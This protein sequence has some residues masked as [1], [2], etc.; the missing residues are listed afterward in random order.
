MICLPLS[1]LNS[2]LC[3]VNPDKVAQNIRE[4]VLLFQ[5]ECFDAV[6]DYF[7]MESIPVAKAEAAQQVYP[8]EMV[9][10]HNQKLLG[11]RID[12]TC[13]VAM[14]PIVEGMGLYWTTQHRK[15][16]ASNR[17]TH[18]AIPVQTSSNV[19]EMICIP[20]TKL[21]GWMCSVN[22]ERVRA[23]LREKVIMYQEECFIVLYNYF[24]KG[25][26]I[27]SRI[28]GESARVVPAPEKKPE[29]VF[30]AQ[31]K[32]PSENRTPNFGRPKGF[33]TN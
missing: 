16:V 19:Q 4:K 18:K 28:M 32:N 13:Y 5:Q 21:N 25:A 1:Q 3:S 20:L 2:W 11:I 8:T 15:I 9:D 29:P 33:L 17:Y 31:P 23:D 7:N 22:P 24:E 30:E 12:G 6:N 14:K 27:N 10:F 26:A